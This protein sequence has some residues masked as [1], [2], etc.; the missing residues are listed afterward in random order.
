[1]GGL[2]T[3]YPIFIGM[4]VFSVSF[5]QHASSLAVV[6]AMSRNKKPVYGYT[7]YGLGAY[8]L[9]WAVWGYVAS[10]PTNATATNT[11]VGAPASNNTTHAAY[12]YQ[13]AAPI[14]PP[15]GK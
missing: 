5:S 1:V 2:D 13:Y 6:L 10:M 3:P 12:T 8:S 7:V 4:I 14:T 15:C 11:P 9:L